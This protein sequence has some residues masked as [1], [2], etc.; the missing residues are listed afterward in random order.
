[1]A[2]TLGMSAAAA[3][4]VLGLPA[5]VSAQPAPVSGGTLRIAMEVR[6]PGD[7]RLFDWPQTGNIAR[8]I[9]ETLARYTADF[10]IE[11]WLLESWD[12]N[13]DAT[14]YTLHLRPDVT[15]SNGDS[16][17]A[18]HVAFNIS[19]WCE[20]HV[21]GN[22]MASRMAALTVASGDTWGP[23]PG[24]I[25]VLDPTTLRLTL[26]RPDITLIASMCD[27]PAL[28]VHPDFNG[29]IGPD[30]VGTGPFTLE[31][32]TP[33]AVAR[34]VRS[35]TPWW[36][37]DIALDAVEFID[38][39]TDPR[40]QIRAWE[41][42]GI[43]LNYE[44]SAAYVDLFDELGLTRS[45]VVSAATIVA[46]MKTTTPP[47]DDRRVRRALQ[48]AVD[49]AVV[50]EIGYDNRGLV[51]ENH[52]VAP[53]HPEY[54]AL[55]PQQAQPARAEREIEAAGHG[56]TMFELVSVDDAWRRDTT[57]VIAAQ[58]RDAGIRVMRR[59]VPAEEYVIN[60]NTYAF[61][62][63][64]W[65]MRPLG[66]QVLALAYRSG[67]AWNESDFADPAFDALLDQAMGLPDADDRR[68]IMAEL[69]LLL[70]Q[71][72]AI[73]QP[74]W[75]TLA[76]HHHPRVQGITMH[77]TFELHLEKVWIVPS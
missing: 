34:L 23:R 12:V 52:Q 71:S 47:Y 36:G 73:I 25:E 21:T 26:D 35:E 11:P 68:K 58:I 30:T 39:G 22:S 31:A 43:D 17:T 4:G 54:A 20:R 44:T 51:A 29:A 62:T 67:E 13:D 45:E 28:I 24:A 49:N 37:G 66:V 64:N 15:W 1:M 72:G 65:S 5:P 8:G 55:P 10:T 41:A 6:N 77:P 16:L 7:P 59:T 63:T 74:Y 3:Y 53:M 32:I 18:E 38:L 48:M 27:Y 76:C 2:S 56:E 40:S 33:G 69:Q 42:D 14:S 60:W 46:R 50:L 57:D 9:V 19:R 75:R 61:S 70:Q